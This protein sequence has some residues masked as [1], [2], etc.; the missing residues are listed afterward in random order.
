MQGETP[1]MR[2]SNHSPAYK[3]EGG[4]MSAI[5]MLESEFQ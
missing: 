3:H 4:Q 1:G 2:Y 5:N